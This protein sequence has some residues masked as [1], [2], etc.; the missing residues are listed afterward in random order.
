MSEKQSGRICSGAS[1]EVWGILPS[2]E[3]LDMG[4]RRGQNGYLTKR[5]PSWLF[6]WRE[7]ARDADGNLVR[8]KRSSVIADASGPGSVSRREAWRIAQRDFV[9]K[10]DRIN[11]KPPSMMTVEDFIEA[12]FVPEHIWKL[13]PG[14][15]AHYA[16]VLPRIKA[17]LGKRRLCDVTPEDVESLIRDYHERGL[18]AQTL[19]H[20]KNVVSA[21][22]RLAKRLR[23]YHEENPASGV[24]LPEIV[25]EK[26]PTLTWEQAR[27]AIERLK[28][29]YREM[30]IL[31]MATSM[32]VAE[33]TGVRVKWVNTTE[34]I[35]VVEGE[36]LPPYSIGVRENWY[37]GKRGTLKRG[38]RR[39]NVPLTPDLAAML[40]PLIDGADPEAPLFRGRTGNPI[41][42]HNAS[43]R[44]LAPLAEKLGYPVTWHAFRRA[45]S[46]FAAQLD[47]PL[48]DRVATM[49]HAQAR[50]TMYYDVADLERRRNLPAAIMDRL[51]GH[52]EGGVQ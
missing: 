19:L 24:T 48:A 20:Y 44:H 35:K 31:S 17:Y 50:M 3:A 10:V 9:P 5:G 36:V 21:I 4:R 39:R 40:R 6:S 30:A 41:D 25:H 51:I 49:G 29:P 47:I 23:L 32:N 43:N 2:Q 38:S 45:H 52:P 42:A 34:S 12:K 14:G 33:V 8:M 27:R 26:R 28:S 18:A 11:S 15:Q 37:Q 46:S 22:F 13:K 1:G 16:Y 7:D